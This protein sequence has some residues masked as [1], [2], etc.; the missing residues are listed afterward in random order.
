MN[1]TC[2]FNFR[3]NLLMLVDALLIGLSALVSEMILSL[4]CVLLDFWT[5]NMYN[6][7]I[8]V[9]EDFVWNFIRLPK[10]RK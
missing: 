8:V 3:K 7:H 10:R 2:K 1:L 9:Q 5:K 4:V 6:G